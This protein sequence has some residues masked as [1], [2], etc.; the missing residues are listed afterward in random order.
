MTNPRII[1]A[2]TLKSVKPVVTN[3]VVEA[4][5]SMGWIICCFDKK[6]DLLDDTTYGAF[7][8]INIAPARSF[9]IRLCEKPN[10]K[11]ENYARENS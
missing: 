6:G 1:R 8:V 2:A 3:P 5:L 4:E 11:T 10:Y 7:S 9:F